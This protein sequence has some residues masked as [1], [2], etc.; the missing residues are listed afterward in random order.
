MKVNEDDFKRIARFVHEVAPGCN[1][2]VAV[3]QP[4]GGT[5]TAS[6]ASVASQRAMLASIAK[7]FDQQLYHSFRIDLLGT[8][9]H[10]GEVGKG[11]GPDS[12]CP[13]LQC[14]GRIVVE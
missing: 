12:R 14:A 13:V 8:C 4:D 3:G 10:C 2:F 11:L 5:T 6:N 1:W 7:S 9:T